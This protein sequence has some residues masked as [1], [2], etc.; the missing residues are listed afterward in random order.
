M[1]HLEQVLPTRLE[2]FSYNSIGSWTAKVENMADRQGNPVP[3]EMA[4]GAS[5][6]PRV[7]FG[8]TISWQH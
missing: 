3:L 7:K 8:S 1:G 4:E 5:I 2:R 6:G